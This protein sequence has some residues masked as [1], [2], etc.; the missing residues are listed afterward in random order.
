MNTNRTVKC[1]LLSDD[2]AP[3]KS[4][5]TVIIDYDFMKNTKFCTVPQDTACLLEQRKKCWRNIFYVC[6]SE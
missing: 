5:L 4:K 6:D 1:R 2:P 3:Q